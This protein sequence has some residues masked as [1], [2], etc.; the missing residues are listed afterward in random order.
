MQN[1]QNITKTV[2]RTFLLNCKRYNMNI[3]THL[4]NNALSALQKII[5]Q[6]TV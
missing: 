2:L 5:F 4:L 6:F 3:V 1:E